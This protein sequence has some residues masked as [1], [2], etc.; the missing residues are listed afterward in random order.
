M[1][2]ITEK[3]FNAL[4]GE[5]TITERDETTQEQTKREALEAEFTARQAEAEARESARQALLSKLGITQEEA[6]LL[7]GGK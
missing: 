4:T 3:E 2:K 6:Q 5:T 7:L 1:M